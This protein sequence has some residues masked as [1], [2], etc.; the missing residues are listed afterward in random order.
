LVKDGFLTDHVRH[1]REVYGHRRDVML[2][3]LESY[4]PPGTTWTKPQGGLFLW[5]RL[6]ES[7]DTLAL[8]PEALDHQVA[9]VPGSAFYADH[10][11]NNTFRLN[12]SN[13]QP[14]MIQEGI[15]RLGTVLDRALLAHSERETAPA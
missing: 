3:S 6:P 15:R 2:D 10:S 11:L 4:F 9:Y 12:F 7:I 1:I 5:V 8:M 13:A 14:A